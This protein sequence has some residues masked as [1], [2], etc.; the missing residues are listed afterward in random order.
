MSRPASSFS[1]VLA[2]LLLLTCISASG[3]PAQQQQRKRFGSAGT[4]ELGGS[5]TF[6]ATQPVLAGKTG[7]WLYE[8]SLLPYA[9]YFPID[10]FELG[11]N[12]AGVNVSKSGDTTAVQLRMLL[13]PAYNFR[14][15]TPITPF[16]EGLAGLTSSSLIRSGSTTSISGFT[17]G[18]RAGIKAAIVDRGVLTLGVQFLRITLNA[19]GASE[20]SGSNELSVSAG[21]TIWI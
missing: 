16:V 21:W 8:F 14:T 11:I 4:L 20:R 13:A 3:A 18:G 1:P 15:G 10:G 2:A 7:S 9:G 12:P 17:F 6:A 19:P 5:V